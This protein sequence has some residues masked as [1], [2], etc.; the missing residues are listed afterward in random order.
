MPKNE[1]ID[2]INQ[3]NKNAFYS[4]AKPRDNNFRALMKALQLRI[5]YTP[6]PS[7]DNKDDFNW[8]VKEVYFASEYIR[9]RNM[10]SNSDDDMKVLKDIWELFD[11]V[12][13]A[14]YLSR[15]GIKYE[16]FL[17]LVASPMIDTIKDTIIS[18]LNQTISQ[19]QQTRVRPKKLVL[20]SSERI[21]IVALQYVL[22]RID[23]ECYLESIS[24]NSNKA[25]PGCKPLPTFSSNMLFEVVDIDDKSHVR[26]RQDGEYLK[27]CSEV[28]DSDKYTCELNNFFKVVSAKID[29]DWKPTCGMM[30]KEHYKNDTLSFV[31]LL[32]ASRLITVAL[33]LAC[34][35]FIYFKTEESEMSKQEIY[36]SLHGDD[37]ISSGL[38]I[39]EPI[40]K[41]EDFSLDKDMHSMIKVKRA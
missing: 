34:T 4:H 1:M 17:Q 29:T 38:A 32:L 41:E 18:N 7:D 9:A 14:L 15:L 35:L 23:T 36:N 28:L 21:N 33:I 26:V 13:D 37:N 25:E 2:Y 12:H 30:P 31:V 16:K 19:R 10:A 24:T 8:L 5:G 22:A 11:L 27:I 3:E 20:F 6:K 40:T 39:F